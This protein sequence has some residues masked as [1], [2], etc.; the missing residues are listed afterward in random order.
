MLLKKCNKDVFNSVQRD[1]TYWLQQC[2][3]K[4][5]DVCNT[6]QYKERKVIV[7]KSVQKKNILFVTVYQ[8]R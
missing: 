4:N 3:K 1:N 7:Y 5:I 6:V 8:E 2:K